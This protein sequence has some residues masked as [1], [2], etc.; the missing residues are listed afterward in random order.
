MAEHKIEVSD[1]SVRV[2]NLEIHNKDISDYL[3]AIPE[4][5]REQ[6]F[7]R[8]VEVG[9]YCIERVQTRQDTE[10]I[11]RQMDSLLLQFENASQLIPEKVETALI[12]KVGVDEGQVFAPLKLIVNDTSKVLAERVKEVKDLLSQEVDPSKETTTLGKALRALKDMLD[13]KRNDSVQGVIESALSRVTTEDGTLAKAVKSVVAESGRSLADEVSKLSMEIR[14]QTTAEEALANTA[15]KGATYEEESIVRLH[16]WAQVVGAQVEYVG[17]DNRPGD[18]LVT[19][20]LTSLPGTDMKT[21][22]EVRDR[23]SPKGR[24]QISDDLSAA[25]AERT[26][27]SGLY[28]SRNVDGLAKEI[29]EW[30]EGQ[31]E[32][33]PW[34][35]CTDDHLL[36]AIRFLVSQERLHELRATAPEVNATSIVAQVQRIRTALERVKNINRYLTDVRTGADSIKDEAEGLRDEVRDALSSIEE[37][38]RSSSSKSEQT[39]AA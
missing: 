14:G 2:T 36:T 6:N 28:L 7:V 17:S 25:M 34:I 26:A 35:A 31:C 21:V 5:E 4:E 8:A 24:K 37:A 38:M 1:T 23:Q 20:P 10:F 9:V 11:R 39:G 30:S 12:G 29:G 22:I 3:R 27:T 32:Q 15:A 33:G 13:P 16:G 18:I 19:I